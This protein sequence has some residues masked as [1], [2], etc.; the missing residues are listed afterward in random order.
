MLVN[1]RPPI[2]SRCSLQ[3]WPSHCLWDLIPASCHNCELALLTCSLLFRPSIPCRRETD[4][5][6]VA[7][8]TP[9]NGIGT[10]L[11]ISPASSSSPCWIMHPYSPLGTRSSAF[12]RPHHRLP[13]NHSLG[14]QTAARCLSSRINSL[15]LPW[16][17]IAPKLKHPA[18]RTIEP[19]LC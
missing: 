2:S 6:W 9:S 1:W 18:Q 3:D 10:G 13:Q 4:I 5:V 12:N 11:S 7:E 19:V 17:T 16:R 15:L 8:Y 14:D